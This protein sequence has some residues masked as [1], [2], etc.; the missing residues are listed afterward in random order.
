MA[1]AFACSDRSAYATSSSASCALEL[2]PH[3]RDPLGEAEEVLGAQEEA[4]GGVAR[5]HELQRVRQVA[6]RVEGAVLL[7]VG[8]PHR[9]QVRRECDGFQQRGLP[10]AVLT[11][12]EG[13]RRVHAQHVEVAYY[14]HREGKSRL[15]LLARTAL[16]L[17]KEVIVR[18]HGGV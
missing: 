10:R 6:L 1:S 7:Q 3:R 2:A 12:E 5:P 9:R 17:A 16:D 18:G 13:H 8:A 4:A 14:G 11:D 15:V